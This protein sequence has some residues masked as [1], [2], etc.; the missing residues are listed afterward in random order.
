MKTL[1]ALLTA[2]LLAWAGGCATGPTTQFKTT[3][4]SFDQP[5]DHPAKQD[6]AQ[7]EINFQGAPLEAVLKIYET[8]SQRT[9]VHGP[10]PDTTIDLHTDTPVGRVE[11]L[12]LLDTTL[13]QHRITMV[14]SGD[15]VV[16]AVPTGK[17]SGEVAPEIDLP[18]QSLPDSSSYM[19]RTIQLQKLQAIDLIPVL[20]PLSKLPNS[21]IVDQKQNLLILRDYAANVKQELRLLET[22]EN[23]PAN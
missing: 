14:L 7:G 9:V 18:W 1:G 4:S 16:K 13:A 19:Q 10:L 21:I 2:G 22:L 15:N 8:V 3:Y 23:K 17:L 20:S 6:K 12:Q 11:T 5:S